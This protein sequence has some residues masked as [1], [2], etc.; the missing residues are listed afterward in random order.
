MP[1]LRT[2]VDGHVRARFRAPDALT[3]YRLV[4]V[5]NAR[6]GMFG[7]GESAVA[8]RKPLMLM[9]ALGQFANVG[10]ELMARAL[11]RNDTGADGSVKVTLVLDQTA[12]SSQPTMAEV[13][14]RNGE[15]RTIDFPVRFRAIGNAHWQWSARLESGGKIFEDDVLSKM[16]VGSPMLVLHE[17]YLNDLRGGKTDLLAGVNPQLAEASGTVSLAIANTRL[18]SLGNSARHLREYPYG[19]AEQ[20]VS[21]LIPWIVLPQLGP[22]L[23][24]FDGREGDAV[25]RSGLQKM[26]TMQTSSGGLS[27]WPGGQRPALFQSAYAAVALGLLQEQGFA[28]PD[29]SKKLLEY[30]S[31]QLRGSGQLRDETELGERALALFALAI[32]GKPEPSYVE[33]LFQRRADLSHGSRALLAMAVM[34]NHGPAPM[35]EELLNVH[36]PAPEGFSFFGGGARETALQLMAWCQFKSK[37]PEVARLTSELLRYRRNGR[38]ETTQENAWALMAL[39]R[40][41]TAVE[42]GGT[43]AQGSLQ[44]GNRVLPFALNKTK[45]VLNESFNFDGTSTRPTIGV[46][47]PKKTLLF[48]EAQ[49]VVHPPLGEQPHQD[50]GFSVA[51]SYRKLMDDG[52]LQAASDL[53]VGDRILVTLRIE[54]AR[55]GR[56]VAIDDPL[57][58]IFEAVNPNFSTSSVG[59][60]ETLESEGPASFRE[61]RADRVLIFCDDLPTGASVFR[62]LARVRS[63]G[64]VTAPA[65]KAEEMYRPERFGLSEITH[66]SAVGDTK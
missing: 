17:T 29:G 15:A 51:R 12:E 44:L 24:K 50:R 56:F 61:I 64:R 36:R 6:T 2:G 57:P 23:P 42:R 62:Y 1:S 45:P 18:V 32:S 60:A 7:S 11:V 54:A 49:F 33:E 38:W 53:R 14:V 63:A 5:A 31:A 41:Y 48:S 58:S 47:N 27:F 65:V 22:I 28:I 52:T 39:A 30:L 13:D 10:D 21:A 25:I 34:E 46:D 20:T 4:A 3:R 37:S 9:P 19:C 55:P 43:A 35:V 40:Y 16:T 59:G 8:I 26:F 66:L